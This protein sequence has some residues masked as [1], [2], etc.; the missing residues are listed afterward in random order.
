MK[1]KYILF[2]LLSFLCLNILAC[3]NNNNINPAPAALD[4]EG[5]PINLSQIYLFE[6]N[7][8]S[9]TLYKYNMITGSYTPVCIDPLCEHE[10]VSSDL[11]SAC[12]FSGVQMVKSHGEWIYF[13]KVNMAFNR[14]SMTRLSSLCAYNYVTGDFNV[15]YATEDGDGFQGV[16]EYYDGFIY[17][18]MAVLNKDGGRELELSKVDINTKKVEHLSIVPR[19]H[20]A[21]IRDI[22]IFSDGVRTVYKT[23][24]SY[25]NRVD[26]ATMPRLRNVSP[27]THGDFVYFFAI[28]SRG[29]DISD[30]LYSLNVNTGETE[31]LAEMEAEGGFVLP[32]IIGEHI[33]YFK[34]EENPPV[35]IDENGEEQKNRYG[36]KIYRIKF[37]GNKEEIFFEDANIVINILNAAEKYLVASDRMNPAEKLVFDTTTGELLRW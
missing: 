33:Y 9:Q 3:T 8:T 36:G 4:G 26:L 28:E 27:V 2:I 11:S 32:I 14:N 17:F 1:K 25:R 37:D 13:A 12:I 23:D 30:V 34:W 15:L 6:R 5:N 19:V 24:L 18:Y 16:F 29:D 20:S 35:Y 21:M 22:F 10:M 7:I 31:E